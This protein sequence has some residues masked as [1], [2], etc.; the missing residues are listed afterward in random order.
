MT[1]SSHTTSTTTAVAGKTR[2]ASIDIVR[3]LVMVIMALDHTRD[4]FHADVAL[5]DPTDLTKTN[6]ALFFTRWITHFCAPTFVFLSGVSAYISTQRK[7]TQE[8]SRFLFTRGLWLVILEFTVVRFGIVF[9]LYYDFIIFQVIWVIGASM[10]VLSALVYLPQK[11]ILG[12]GLILIFGHNLLDAIRISPGE[13]GHFLWAIMQ[14][15]GFF[16]VATG[17]VVLAA[18]PLLSWLGIMLAGY[19]IGFIYD[20]GFEA[21]Q[22]RRIL[23]Y[24]GIACMAIFI[25][26]RFT[27]A[28]GDPSPWSAQNNLTFTLLSFINV[29]KYPVSLLYT[30]LM[31]GPVLLIL[32]LIENVKAKAVEPLRI[33]GRVPLFYYILHFYLIHI[34]SLILYMIS[35]GKSWSEL[36]FNFSAG[37]GGIPAG[38]GYTLP[39]VYV[40]W[41]CIVSALYPV[42]KR[43]YRYKSQHTQWWL[44][45]L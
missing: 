21:A 27:N 15:S 44:G 33:I 12:L 9:N 8:L 40:A 29:T 25:V 22:R 11:T 39:W 26:L 6:P 20:R 10:M 35:Q 18:Y 31:L 34:S 42:C 36:D 4:F 24:S 41:I 17:H 37:F 1:L 13:P 23:I 38:A 5:F 14:Q 2:I 43:Y 19:G 32:P 16:P 7:T 28:Y 3:G 45:Y 30:L